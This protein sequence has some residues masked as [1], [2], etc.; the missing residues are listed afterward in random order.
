MLAV[1]FVL[2]VLLAIL[3][4]HVNA[5][6]ILSLFGRRKL[7]SL[8]PKQGAWYHLSYKV[9]RWSIPITLATVGFLLLLGSPFLHASFSTAD[10]GALPAGSSA[11]IVL[12][13]LTHDFSHQ[14][15]T[16]ID[17]VVRTNGNATSVAN[18]ETL[19]NYTQR[20][21]ALTG[22]TSL[23]SLVNVDSRLT[24]ADYE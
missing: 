14:N 8:V 2:P 9:M 5:L 17:I 15:D 16:E 4:R 24:L 10:E 20:V 23:V 7:R 11:A 12:D 6:S 13:H 21:Q 19:S 1:L 3:G 22:I 18:L